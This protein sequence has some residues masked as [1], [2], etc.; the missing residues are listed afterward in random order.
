MKK[1]PETDGKLIVQYYSEKKTAKIKLR[2]KMAVEMESNP[3]TLHTKIYRI[4]N[5]LKKCIHK[6][7]NGK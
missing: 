5:T 4:R 2:R 6:C 1:L 7:L 3:G